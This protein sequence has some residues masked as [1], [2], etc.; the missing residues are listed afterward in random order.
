MSEN[1]LTNITEQI[2]SAKGASRFELLQK[3]GN[4]IV[5]IPIIKFENVGDVEGTK[6]IKIA[7]EESNG[8]KIV[9]IYT[10]EESF[11]ND[12]DNVKYQCL[13]LPAGD[14]ALTLPRNAK[15]VIDK[16]STII[17]ELEGED[18]GVL[19]G[20]NLNPSWLKESPTEEIVDES[21]YNEEI[22]EQ[23]EHRNLD[24]MNQLIDENKIVA[25]NSDTYFVPKS[26]DME[27]K[28]NIFDTKQEELVDF[29]TNV[30]VETS[31][32]KSILENLF[33]QFPEIEE[34]YIIDHKNQS[35]ALG[36]LS[37]EMSLESRFNLVEE[38]ANISREFFGEAG[39]IEVYDDLSAST[40]TSWELFRS[41][42]P[43]YEKKSDDKFNI[44]LS[45]RI[46]WSKFQNSQDNQLLTMEDEQEID[47]SSFSW[48]S[49][50]RR[51]LKLFSRTKQ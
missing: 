12:D 14:L 30:E 19:S 22:S 10:S 26:L 23:V 13:N 15:L 43:F 7:Q 41:Y 36:I 1:I 48:K 47:E 35:I 31:E 25:S 51:G 8:Q 18:I 24:F 9:N 49:L 4:H 50:R 3:F 17:A 11:F 38:I 45:S 32:I 21:N 42:T 33:L 40:S 16:S 37:E 46:E 20:L 5:Y 6:K 28:I 44:P 34:A 2:I 27:N 39:S 29:S